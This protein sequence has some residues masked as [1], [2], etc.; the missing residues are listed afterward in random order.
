[1]RNDEHGDEVEDMGE[2]QLD[3]SSMATVSGALSSSSEGKGTSSTARAEVALASSSTKAKGYQLEGS[4]PGGKGF[5]PS[6]QQIPQGKKGKHSKGTTPSKPT[7]RV[8][9]QRWGW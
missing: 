6:I 3:P 5:E 9:P 1:M 2:I 7:K 4:I 8:L